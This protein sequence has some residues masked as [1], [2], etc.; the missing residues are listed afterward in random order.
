MYAT[1][2][3]TKTEAGPLGRTRGLRGRRSRDD[4]GAMAGGPN[5]LGSLSAPATHAALASFQRNEASAVKRRGGC[6][7]FVAL[8]TIAVVLLVAFA[9]P[10]APE[11]SVSNTSATTGNSRDD[12]VVGKFAL[13]TTATFHVTNQNFFQM[14]FKD[15]LVTAKSPAGSSF[16][17]WASSTAYAVPA[18]NNRAFTISASFNTLTGQALTN[19]VEALSFAL[20]ATQQNATGTS[21]SSL[22]LPD[23]LVTTTMTP[24]WLSVSLPKAN[25]DFRVPVTKV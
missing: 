2:Q 13:T 14:G 9:V 1:A 10:R 20:A 25:F 15:V 8:I 12:V 18:R 11:V 21:S 23:L 3:S 16:A 5:L 24:V 4:L 22:E 7:V 6:C 19:A 17:S